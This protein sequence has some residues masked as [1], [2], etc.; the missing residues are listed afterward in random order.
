MKLRFADCV[1]DLRARQ[2]E[3]QGRTVPLEPK[4]YELLEVLIERRPAVVTSSE[5]DELLWPK[6]Y[7]GRA[8][9]A[10]LVS[11][12]RTALGDTPRGSRVIRT[13]YKSGYAFCAEVA[14]VPSASHA[15]ASIELVWNRQT[16]ALSEG[17]HLAGRDESCS[18]LIDANTVSRRQ[19][20]ILVVAG[21]VTVEDLDST[22]GTLV[23]GQRIAHATPLHPG[24]QLSFGSEQ[25]QV[26]RRKAH[27]P[28]VKVED[29]GRR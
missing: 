22:N 16:F 26:R 23:N 24:D 1:V 3:R 29:R 18:L 20:R 27:A 4:V 13:A 6:V 21:G 10:R 8:S 9:L 17:E 28:T 5:L 11:Q 19:A 12:L 15:P 14:S 7:V 2:L 25:L